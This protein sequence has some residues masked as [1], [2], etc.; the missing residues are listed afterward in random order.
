MRRF[1]FTLDPVLR[2]RRRLVEHAQLELAEQQRR[3]ERETAEQER[4]RAALHDFHLHRAG[5]QRD[6]VDIQVLCEADRYAEAL[7]HALLLRQ[8]RVQQAAAAVKA[9]LEELQQRRIERES[10]ERLRERRLDEHRQ[11]E[12]RVEQQA[13][14]EAAVL[15]W[16]R[17]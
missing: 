17:K 8:Q 5:L 16:G 10:L 14:D 15:R 1:R 2:L 3:L 11:E 4:A 9:C 6:A 7:A 12:Q 13:L